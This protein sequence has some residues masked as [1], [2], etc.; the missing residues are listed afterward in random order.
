MPPVVR[1]EFVVRERLHAMLREGRD[2]GL[3]LLAAGPG[4]GKS[5]LL[6]AW[7]AEES[8]SRP[9]AW[10]TLTEREDDP[11]ALCA[12]VLEAIRTVRPR[13]GDDVRAVLATPAPALDEALQRL[14]N[15]LAR[16]ESL[17][18]VLDDF[19]RIKSRDAQRV[20]GWIAENS[21]VAAQLVVATRADPA[22]PLGSLRA[23]G[24][25]V[26]LRAGELALTR[27]EA[28]EFLVARLGLDLSADDVGLL[29][30]RTE[31]WPAGLYL[32]ALSA[33]RASDP[34]EFVGLFGASS[35]H[36]VDFFVDEV[37]ERQPAELQTF[38]T[39]CSILER[40]S[41]PLCDAVLEREGADATLASLSGENLF[42][43][44][45]GDHGEWYRFHGLFA[46]VLRNELRRREPDLVRGLHLR[47]ATWY[48]EAGDLVSALEHVLAAG[49]FEE[50]ADLIARNW[51]ALE[52]AGERASVRTW[53]DRL[54]PEVVSARAD[55]MNAELAMMAPFEA[56]GDGV[57]VVEAIARRYPRVQG[58]PLAEGLRRWERGDAGGTLPWARR[59]VGAESPES[60][61][62]A[63][64]CFALGKC[65]HYNG[66]L[67]EGVRWLREARAAALAGQ[68]WRT[69]AMA[70]AELSL[71][72]GQRG[73]AGEQER[74][75]DEAFARLEQ[76]GLAD[77]PGTSGVIHTARGAALAARGRLGEAR[78][79]LERGLELRPAAY[80]ESL[81]AMLPLIPVVRA[82]GDHGRAS[83]L[84]A[85][86]RSIVAGCPDPGIFE[87]RLAGLER[88]FESRPAWRHEGAGELTAAELR[89]L[90]LLDAGR[91]EREI[92]GELYVTFNTV[93]THVKSI[94]R[95]FGIGSRQEALDAARP[96][97][98]L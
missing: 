80:L 38:M 95:K 39:R 52:N 59:M 30:R 60:D 22:L 74:F 35:R 17:A 3:T 87:R 61:F 42:L 86:A 72:A 8:R 67:V 83:A 97:G 98:L 85:E 47:A 48:R 89:V 73:D 93:H 62:W 75:A 34:H 33:R 15:A 46:E 29:V 16:E 27:A 55:L 9:V 5:T 53:L 18:L 41:G 12:H 63:A 36:V 66:E 1:P 4:F 76:H 32:A 49:A 20:V 23:H 57:R 70:A 43:G 79:A 82:L 14:A 19:Q 84:L 90:R 6:A 40:L 69:A 21:P 10:L 78:T 24:E 28:E 88:A 94:Y 56:R 13:F 2:R 31:G 50:A 44:A 37:L 71:V 68:Q 65:L 96:L 58:A 81:D 64:A 26:E 54:P 91:S 45:L 11:V 25:L 77:A 92:A 7:R 51:V